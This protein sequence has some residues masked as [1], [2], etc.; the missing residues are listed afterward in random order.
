MQ[1]FMPLCMTLNCAL[2][3][4]ITIAA[5][6]KWGKRERPLFSGHRWYMS[7]STGCYLLVGAR[8]C[9]TWRCVHVRL[10][11]W[12]VDVKTACCVVRT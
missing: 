2:T 3:T 4:V 6:S 12:S 10:A 1:T 9:V 11:A 5:C 7:R 8:W